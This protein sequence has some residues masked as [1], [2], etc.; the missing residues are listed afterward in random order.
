MKFPTRY[1]SH[2]RVTTNVGSRI[3]KLYQAQYDDEGRIDLVEVGE[4]DLYEAIQS[5]KD[6]VDIHV[7]LKQFQQG[8]TEALMRRQATFGDFTQVPSSYAELLNSVIAG[9]QYFNQLPVE[10]RAR[11]GHS[12]SQW[13]VGMDKPDF[14]EKMGWSVPESEPA[15]ASTVESVVEKEE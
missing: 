6:S 8:D 7:L 13:M 10:V 9:E 12:F 2:E 4:E 11:F 14:A 5:H 3:H 1:D 15:A